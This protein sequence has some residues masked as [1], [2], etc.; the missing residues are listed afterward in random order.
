MF[1]RSAV[2]KSFSIKQMAF[3]VLI[4]LSSLLHL[5][6]SIYGQAGTDMTGTGGR[7]VIQGRIYYPSGQRIDTRMQ[8]KLES[9][10]SGTL[11]VFSDS[12]GFFRFVSLTP[13]SYTVIIDGG[14]AFES[15]RET[16][17]IDRDL[18]ISS[19]SKLPSFTRPYTVDVNLQPKRIVQPETKSGIIDASLAAVPGKAKELYNRAL[20]ASHSND[21]KKAVELL[22]SAIALYPDFPQAYNELG[23]LYLRKVEL[24]KAA[25]ALQ[26][27]LRLK[28]EDFNSRLNYGIVLLQKQDYVNAET[29]L[30]AAV[31]LR[32]NAATPHLY[33]G[34][35]LA[36]QKKDFAEA[37]AELEKAIS[38]AGS[39]N[40]AMA[41]KYLGGI[42]WGR[43]NKRAADELEKYLKLS[44]KAADAEQIRNA[45]KELRSRQ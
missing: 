22:K 13:G 42:F 16:V 23:V 32:N 37:Q 12:N 3:C 15:I 27:A 38:L 41:H 30:R 21:M 26:T 24:N 11:T 31:K 43:D 28:P 34:I 39:D 17:Y 45:I 44:P 8:V 4:A 10:A 6:S 5:S 35:S 25:E 33:L 18:Q 2:T 20:E 36:K 40:L 1:F 7:H 9:T 19:S 14:E 29:E